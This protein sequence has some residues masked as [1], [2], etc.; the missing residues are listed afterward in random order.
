MKNTIKI[1]ITLFAF[2]TL[3][4][5][6]AQAIS[7]DEKD[8]DD[9]A[10]KFMLDKAIKSYKKE[11]E[12]NP[13][14]YKVSEKLAN[15]LLIIDPNSNEAL[16]LLSE[17]NNSGFMSSRAKL[18]YAQMLSSKGTFKEASEVYN[19]FFTE[20]QADAKLTNINEEYFQS[21]ATPNKS[22]KIR[23][24]GELNSRQ[25]DFSPIF[26]R[27][28]SILYIT[29]SK[30]RQGSG[31]K[32]VETNYDMFT[33]VF[34]AEGNKS[35]NFQQGKPFFKKM[36]QSYMQGP[37]TFTKDYGVMYLTRTNYENNKNKTVVASDKKTVN[38]KIFR[39]TYSG[40]LDEWTDVT[41]IK[42]NSAPNADDYSYAHPA[43]SPN[44]DELI[45]ASN[46]PGG[47]GGTDLW[48]V[49][50]VGMGWGTPENLGPKINTPGEEKFPYIAA[51]GTLFFASDGLPG[52]GGLDIFKAKFANEEYETPENLGNPIN[53]K[54]D[55]F[56][57]II[58]KD[59]KEGFFS[60]NRNG[61]IGND[62][63]YHWKSVD[64]MLTV[65]VIDAKTKNPIESAKIAA[66]CINKPDITTNKDG[67]YKTSMMASKLCSLNVS[68][69]GY[70]KNTAVLKNF[71]ETK[72]VVV[73]LEEDL[74]PTTKFVVSVKDCQTGE[75]LPDANVTLKQMSSG[76]EVGAFTKANGTLKVGGIALNDEYQVRIFKVNQDGTRYLAKT[77]SVRT[78]PE[79]INQNVNIDVCLEKIEKNKVFKI[80]NIYFDVNKWNIRPDAANELEKVVRIMYENPTLV[81][82]MGSHTDCRGSDQANLVLS[83]KRAQSSMEY[84]ASRGVERNRLSFRGYGETMPVNNCRCIT[85]NDCS[86]YEHQMNRRTEFKVIN[87]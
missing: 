3:I 21:I 73:Q 8:G 15:V 66:E 16:K 56:G 82:E 46:M 27:N 70:K 20:S 28:R 23:N 61:G 4:N 2:S 41:E 76:D 1:L 43:L 26:Y 29:T 33:D 5:L 60:S 75:L 85:K 36:D 83:Q 65:K 47:F 54:D 32:L 11:L 30:N 52:L 81:I 49:R 50:R 35:Y 86:E 12:T 31:F 10:Q 57:F 72:I 44:D 18:R 9:A 79:N 64:I 58:D 71:N 67:E 69:E 51:D 77:E 24:V 6:N 14:N 17:A 48:K 74:S 13:R 45:F 62:D 38:L 68:K 42:L 37:M 59:N 40:S 84:I 7:G 80:D 22:I 34:V 19:N 78:R 25:A 39:V 53:T 55:D 63:I 87:F